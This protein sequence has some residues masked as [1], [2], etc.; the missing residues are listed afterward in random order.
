MKSSYVTLREP[1][2]HARAS[3]RARPRRLK[4]GDL[5]RLGSARFVAKAGLEPDG[6][7]V[8]SSNARA[9]HLG[10]L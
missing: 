8:G 1:E 2:A 10:K 9:A 5:N 4:A 3:I 7:S 6:F